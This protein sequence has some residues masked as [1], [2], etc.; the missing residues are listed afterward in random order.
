MLAPVQD[1][2]RLW[3]QAIYPESWTGATWLASQRSN[4]GQRRRP[5]GR[6]RPACSF[7]TTLQAV[8]I[9][10]L[11][12]LSASPSKAGCASR[13]VPRRCWAPPPLSPARSR[14]DS[15][16]RGPVPGRAAQAHGGS[17]LGREASWCATLKPWTLFGSVQAKQCF[18]N[19]AV[20]YV[21]CPDRKSVRSSMRYLDS[22][23]MALNSTVTFAWSSRR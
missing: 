4:R 1:L 6:Q 20:Y 7:C 21:C 2:A 8:S 22:H 19:V 18:S 9:S 13:H 3:V 23:G 15:A 10:L 17:N 5:T 11:L 16:R 14:A 12:H